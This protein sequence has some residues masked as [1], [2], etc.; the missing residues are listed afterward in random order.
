[1]RSSHAPCAQAVDRRLTDVVCRNFGNELRILAHAGKRHRHI[2]FCTA[3]GDLKRS[4]LRQARIA[5]RGQAH[6]QFAKGYDFHP[7]TS[8]ILRQFQRFFL[9]GGKAANEQVLLVVG[10]DVDFL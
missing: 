1:M 2:R 9:R 5:G 8:R 10:G 4:C 7:I 3:E 6:H